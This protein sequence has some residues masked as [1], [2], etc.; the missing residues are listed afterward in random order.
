MIAEFG[1]ALA[2]LVLGLAAFVALGYLGK[3]YDKRIAGVLLTFPIL[4]GIGIL[5]GDDPLVVADSIYAVVVFNGL[6]LFLMISWCNAW[7]V[8]A[9]SSPNRKLIVRL[10]TW[11]TV[12]AVGATLVTAFR[13]YLPGV[14]GLMLIQ[15]AITTAAVALLWKA[16]RH[17]TQDNT[18]V[19][20]GWRDHARAMMVLWSNASGML[21]MGLFVLSCVVLFLAA[22]VF[23]SKWVGMF[24][25]LPLPGLFAVA[26]LSVMEQEEDF[27]LMRDSVLIGPVSVIAFNW[28]YAQTVLALPA[29]FAAHMSLGIAALVLLLLADAALIF[30]IVPRMSAYLDRV[31]Q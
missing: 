24:S 20:F 6:V 26:T 25:A 10:L 12:W 14:L 31:R 4:N 28:L 19:G 18:P 7:P 13:A 27:D 9:S 8:M 11:T 29:D 17:V 21:R 5:T 15:L 2:K 1:M 22:Q 3:F 23:T 30:W 16:P